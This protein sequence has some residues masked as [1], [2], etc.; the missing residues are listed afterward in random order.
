[1][2]N[3]FIFLICFSLASSFSSFGQRAASAQYS[4]VDSVEYDYYRVLPANDAL[5]LEIRI[6]SEDILQVYLNDP[7]FNYDYTK[8]EPDDW[9]A[10]IKNWINQQIISLTRSESFSTILDYLYYGLMLLALILIVR[11]LIKGDRRGLFF[12]HVNSEKIKFSEQKE[13]ITMPNLEDLISSAIQKK[14][15]KLAVRYLFL[16]SLQLLSSKGIIELKENK[17]NYQ[18]LSE[19]KNVSVSNA[20]RKTTS[21]FERVWYGDFPIDNNVFQVSQQEFNELFALVR[22]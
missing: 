5:D 8:S 21:R 16:K 19:I 3:R 15:Y 11:G 17:T 6:P 20:F 7:D 13:E 22:T 1:M 10:K 14:D 18:Y 12:G 9:F 4:A 2:I